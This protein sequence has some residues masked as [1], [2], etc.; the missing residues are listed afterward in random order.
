MSYKGWNIYD[1]YQ[2]LLEK[3]NGPIAE[4]HT[5]LLRDLHNMPFKWVLHRDEFRAKDGMELRLDY[6]EENGLTNTA[7]YIFTEYKDTECSVLEMMIALAEYFS[8]DVVGSSYRSTAQWFW[9]MIK[10][11]GL[12]DMTDYNYSP[13]L[14]KRHIDTFIDR[15]YSRNGEG[16]MFPLRNPSRDQRT[17]EIWYQLSEW[18]KENFWD[19]NGND[20]FY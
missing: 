7:D 17:V 9:M 2:W 5:M 14:V 19:L 11:L 4:D 6:M 16:G 15:T 13:T 8:K 1:Y 10:N 20:Q 3:I 18:F 12:L